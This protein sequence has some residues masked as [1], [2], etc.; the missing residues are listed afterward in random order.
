LGDVPPPWKLRW[1]NREVEERYLLL[2]CTDLDAMFARL[3]VD[4]KPNGIDRH[5][6]PH[7]EGDDPFDLAYL[8]SA[9]FT[10]FW[11]AYGVRCTASYFLQEK[12]G[13]FGYRDIIVTDIDLE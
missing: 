11:G 5:R 9:Y 12:E 8:Y 6:V 3:E 7:F 4:P 13:P 1:V 2:K 10:E